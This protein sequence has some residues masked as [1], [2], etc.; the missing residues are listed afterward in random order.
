MALVVSIS[1]PGVTPAEQTLDLIEAELRLGG[2][3]Q[4]A[5]ERALELARLGFH[6][7]KTGTGWDAYAEALARSQGQAWLPY[8]MLPERADDDAWVQQKLFFHY[9][10][11]PALTALRCPLLAVLGGRDSG[12]PVEENRSRWLA[13]LTAGGHRDHDLI[14]IPEANHV[15][16]SAHTGSLFEILELDGFASDYRSALLRWLR[17]RFSLP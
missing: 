6:Y 3:A 5:I 17:P 2:F 10:P 7:G 14:V 4:G 11:A 9:D 12:I 8:L 15:M 1:G 13:A 16:F